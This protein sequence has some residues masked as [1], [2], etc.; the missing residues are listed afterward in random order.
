MTIRKYIQTEEGRQWLSEYVATLP[1][2]EH[3]FYIEIH[4][5][6]QTPKQR[7]AIHVFFRKLAKELNDAG[8]DMRKVLKP[9][10]DIP[11]TEHSVK[12]HLWR[13]ILETMTGKHSTEDQD[14]VEP[15]AVYSVLMKHLSEKFGVY[16]GFPNKK[17]GL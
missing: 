9:E 16:V 7:S 8:L 3:G 12:E 1:L 14:R 17:D 15:D 5:Q 13:P 2:G 11:W 4:D 10:A 6:R